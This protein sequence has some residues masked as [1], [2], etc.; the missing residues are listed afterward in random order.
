MVSKT[1]KASTNYNFLES[2]TTITG[3]DNYILVL[4]LLLCNVTIRYSHLSR[5]RIDLRLLC[6]QYIGPNM[7]F[8]WCCLLYLFVARF[9]KAAIS[10]DTLNS[11]YDLLLLILHVKTAVN[12]SVLRLWRHAVC[13]FSTTE[14][15]LSKSALL[16]GKL[17]KGPLLVRRTASVPLPS[18]SS[19]FT[20]ITVN[21]F[22]YTIFFHADLSVP[23]K[24]VVIKFFFDQQEEQ[25]VQP[26]EQLEHTLVHPVWL[27]PA[28][29]SHI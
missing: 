19:P 11:Q 16:R 22:R 17:R 20:P 28:Q 8:Y 27:G 23:L 2:R 29:Q 9:A 18:L 4:Y 25:S 6:G 13:T 1:M 24:L 21:I 10:S 15:I 5:I 26:D 14:H 12:I 7:A 3:I